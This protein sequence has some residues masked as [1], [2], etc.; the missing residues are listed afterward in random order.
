MKRLVI[1]HKG[2]A[3]LLLTALLLLNVAAF[4]QARECADSQ[5]DRHAIG[6]QADQLANQEDDGSPLPD[7][8]ISSFD[9]LPVDDSMARIPLYAPDVSMLTHQEP[10]R[11]L[12]QV[13]RDRFIPPRFN[14]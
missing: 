9:L 1:F 2:L 3:L 5:G 6:A 13:V 12:P 8:D 11:A 7:F 14:S 10:F 4:G